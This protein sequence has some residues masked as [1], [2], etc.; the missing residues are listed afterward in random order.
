M[1]KLKNIKLEFKNESQYTD[2]IY[3]LIK[4]EKDGYVS[5]I[6]FIFKFF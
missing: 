3:Y 5:N 6:C 2:T 4:L 1:K